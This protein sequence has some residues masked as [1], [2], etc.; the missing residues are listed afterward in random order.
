MW[1]VK[2]RPAPA[3]AE[4]ESGAGDDASAHGHAA[5]DAPK[6]ANK[7]QKAPPVQKAAPAAGDDGSVHGHAAKEAPKGAKKVQKGTP[8]VGEDVSI[9]RH[10]ADEPPK[11]AKKGQKA[12]LNISRTVTAD[13][14]KKGAGCGTSRLKNS[15][16][17]VSTVF[18]FLSG[19][20]TA[21]FSPPIY[22]PGFRRTAPFW[23][24]NRN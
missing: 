3:H 10:A 13:A 4:V 6:G 24:R 5:D 15:N 16:D 20:P 22:R 21:G 11:V 2:K 12:A 23:A 1:S 9:H 8:G 14:P 18:H 17:T 19:A 7:V